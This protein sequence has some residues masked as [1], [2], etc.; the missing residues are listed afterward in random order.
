MYMKTQL[1]KLQICTY[2]RTYIH[3]VNTLDMICKF[4]IIFFISGFI[5]ARWMFYDSFQCD[6]EDFSSLCNS[7]YNVDNHKTFLLNAAACEP[8]DLFF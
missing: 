7:N 1:L 2:V 4:L 5:L 3:Y 8:P 6:L